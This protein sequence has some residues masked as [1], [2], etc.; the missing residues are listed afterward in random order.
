MKR[1]LAIGDIHATDR[2]LRTLWDWVA[3]TSRD[4]VVFLGDYVDRGPNSNAVL[5]FLIELH[6]ESDGQVRFLL[7]NHERMMMDARHDARMRQMWLMSGGAETMASYGMRCIS[8]LSNESW[9]DLVP[10][11]HWHFLEE[12]CELFID[13]GD[14][15]FVHAGLDPDL[16]LADQRE[17]D[18]LWRRHHGGPLHT[19]GKRVICGH[20]EQRSHYPLISEGAIIA[21]TFAYGDGPLTCISIDEQLAHQQFACGRR[22]SL[23]WSSDFELHEVP[24]AADSGKANKSPSNERHSTTTG[25]ASLWSESTDSSGS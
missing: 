20:N 12:N 14:I 4:L 22:R 17:R 15:L 11:A 16:E 19:C 9:V 13:D 8:E 7:G 10:E 23:T 24:S 25:L 6:A 21:D 18:L 2:Q 5:G 3:P 1:R